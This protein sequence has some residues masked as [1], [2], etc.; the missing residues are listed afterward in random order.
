MKLIIQIPCL[1]EAETLPL[2]WPRLPGSL[3]GIDEIE[4][5]VVDDGS[6]DDTEEVARKLG[7]THVVRLTTRKGLASA[8]REGLAKALELGADLIVNT[9]ADNQYFGEDIERLVAPILRGQADIVIGDRQ[10]AQQAEFTILKR[11][12]QRLGS[13]VV[14]SLS[15]LDVPDA[16][17]GFRAYSRE[18]A[19]RTNV[20]SSFTY[21]HETIL[22]AASKNLKVISVPVR[23]NP[24]TR[25]SRLTKST[26]R[27][28]LRS[29]LTILHAYVIYAPLRVFTVAGLTLFLPGA[30]L[31]GRFF[32]YYVITDG[33]TG[34]VQSLII[35]IGLVTSSA[36]VFLC[37]LVA[38]LVRINRMLVEDVQ[39]TVRSRLRKS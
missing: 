39:Y 16:A 8:F 29:A 23:T 1:N 30:I 5:L 2:T 21:T 38:D 10:V 33:Q 37:G 4:T 14:R 28:V 7:A 15:G 35:G 34:Y 32:Y 24:S 22:Q 19:L 25:R 26:P 12:L 9:D 18:A 3:P 27:Y 20:V 6:T 31:T 17:S 11:L 13:W 36:F